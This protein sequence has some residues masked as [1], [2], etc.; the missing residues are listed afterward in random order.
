MASV[1]GATY[2]ASQVVNVAVTDTKGVAVALERT[3]QLPQA[4]YTLAEVTPSSTVA[5]WRNP[6]FYP[7][8]I[9]VIG[10]PVSTAIL[11]VELVM[12]VELKFDDGSAL[13]LASIPPPVSNELVTKVSNIITSSAETFFHKS[14]DAA[15]KVV[16]DMALVKL[17]AFLAP[18]Q[19]KAAVEM[20]SYAAIPMLD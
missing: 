20:L 13:L 4:F 5:D 7:L 11:H 1:D 6:G 2:G 14:V 17:A 10:A 15:G 12:H 9:S 19:A 8:S 16:R 18:P 3:D